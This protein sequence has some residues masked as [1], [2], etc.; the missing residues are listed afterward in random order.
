MET[1]QKSLKSLTELQ[2][3]E[4]KFGQSRDN[5]DKSLNL[6]HQAYSLLLEGNMFDEI[7]TPPIDSISVNAVSLNKLCTAVCFCT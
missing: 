2:E 3:D 6:F 5:M 1:F 7:K 4:S